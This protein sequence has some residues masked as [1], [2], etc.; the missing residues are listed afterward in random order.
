MMNAI[1]TF[2][3]PASLG[4]FFLALL[5]LISSQQ[6][7]AGEWSIGAAAAIEQL[8]YRSYDTQVL[9]APMINYQGEYIFVQGVVAGVHLYKTETNIVNLNIYYSPLSFDP[10]KSDNRAL[11]ELDKRHSTAMAGVSYYH[12]ADWGNIRAATATDI[13]D[14][15][16][17][18]MID[19]SYHYPI[20]F[21]SLR[22]ETGIG[23]QWQ[24]RKHNDYYFGVSHRESHNSEL[25]YYNAKAGV[26]PYLA[27]NM[28]YVFNKNW[29]ALVFGRYNLL[30]KEVKDSPMTEKS[31]AGIFGLGLIYQF[32]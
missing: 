24:D 7:Y 14:N 19:L 17:G 5:V 16:K 32:D 22:I 11:R 10:S 2:C 3:R 26:S 18:T 20:Q 31:Y 29:Q 15:S 30:D 23:A 28:H 4:G 8:P 12:Q 9:A 21:K 1:N 25:E 13:L 6:T 27:L